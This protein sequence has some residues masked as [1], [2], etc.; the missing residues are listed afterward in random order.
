MPLL[1]TCLSLILQRIQA[2]Q[3]MSAFIIGPMRYYIVELRHPPRKCRW[4]DCLLSNADL[5]LTSIVTDTL[6]FFNLTIVEFLH[7]GIKGALRP[8]L[9]R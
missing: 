8:V 7:H 3:S 9:V 4:L 2:L 1:V 6:Q 5:S